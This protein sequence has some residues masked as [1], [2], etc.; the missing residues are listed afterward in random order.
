[1]IMK[2]NVSMCNYTCDDGFVESGERICSANGNF[3]GG[4]CK[5]QYCVSG[6]APTVYP[7]LGCDGETHLDMQGDGRNYSYDA[8]G[9]CGGTYKTSVLINGQPNIGN[10]KH[11]RPYLCAEIEARL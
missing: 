3:T 11:D 6:N 5:A 4:M 7:C 9:V 8:C 2:N 1:M 10:S